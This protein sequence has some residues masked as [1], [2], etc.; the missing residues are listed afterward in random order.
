MKHPSLRKYLNDEIQKRGYI[1]RYEIMELARKFGYVTRGLPYRE[2]N[3][4]RRLRKS[5]SPCVEEV[6]DNGV[7]VAYKWVGETYSPKPIE[8]KEMT[9]EE[10]IM[11][12]QR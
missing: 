7:I 2:S 6:F 4:E 1:A 8:R 9:K 11:M 3:A 10:M 12:S 5:E